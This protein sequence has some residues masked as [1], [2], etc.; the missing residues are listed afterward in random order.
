MNDLYLKEA[1]NNVTTSN[2]SKYKAYSQI[3][4]FNQQIL[5]GKYGG[6]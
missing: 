5:I 4:R 2:K 6:K 1:N 3:I